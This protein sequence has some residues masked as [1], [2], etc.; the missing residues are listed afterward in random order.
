MARAPIL[1]ESTLR[2]MQI[3]KLNALRKSIGEDLGTKVFTEWFN[4]RPAPEEANP[5]DKTAETIADAVMALISKGKI[6]SLPR[7]GYTIKR[8]R[9]RVVVEQA[10]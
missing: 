8:G 4:S 6:K 10:N 3:R 1:D 9:N 7:G 5:V 2:K